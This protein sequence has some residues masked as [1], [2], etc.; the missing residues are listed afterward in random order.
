M[1]GLVGESRGGGRDAVVQ[2]HHGRLLVD[3]P[4]ASAGE[5]YRELSRRLFLASS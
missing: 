3:G 1:P 5:P 2:R 4:T